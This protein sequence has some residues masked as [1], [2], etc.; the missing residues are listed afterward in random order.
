MTVQSVH[1]K[2]GS[3]SLVLQG[4]PAGVMDRLDYFGHIAV[5]PGVVNPVE[6][7]DEILDLARFVGVYRRKAFARGALTISGASLAV[8][9][10]DEDDK[11]DI[12]EYPGITLTGSTFANAVRAILPASGS[13][14]EGTL[15]PGVAGTYTGQHLYC[16]PRAALDYICDTMRAEW[17]V[18]ND[19]TLDAGPAAS[20]FGGEPKAVIVRAGEAGVDERLRALEGNLDTETNAEDYI[21]RS[22][23]V[24]AA[25]GGGTANAASVPYKHLHGGTVKVTRLI[26]EQD[27]TSS[28]NAASRAQNFLNLWSSP[29][30]SLKLQ[31][32]SFDIE[33]DFK[34]GETVW[35]Y[36]PE[37]GIFDTANEITFRGR[38]INPMKVR[39]LG[40]TWPVTQGYTVGFRRSQ[41]GA[42]IDLTPWVQWEAASAGEI[43]ISDSPDAMLGSSGSGS[44]GT[45]IDGGG[46]GA[47]DIASP[48]AP[49]WTGYTTTT[50]ENGVGNPEAQV[51]VTWSTPNNTDGSTILDGDHYE[52]QYRPVGS[53]AWQITMVPWGTNTVTLQALTPAT[54]YE[55]QVRAVDYFRPPNYG[56]W[57]ATSI[58]VTAVDTTPP[59]TPAAPTVAGSRIAIQVKHTLGSAGGGTYNLPVDLDHLE[60]HVGATDTFTAD[61]TTRVG[62]IPANAGMILGGIPAVGSFGVEPTSAVWVRVRA[63]DKTGNKSPASDSVTVTALLIDN[64]HISDLTVSKLTAGTMTAAVILGGSIKTATTGARLELDSAGMRL[65]NASGVQ[66][67]TFTTATGAID[68]NGT[69]ATGVSGQRIRIDATSTYPTIWFKDNSGVNQSFINAPGSGLGLNTAGDGIKYSRLYLLDGQLELAVLSTGSQAISGG[70]FNATASFTQAGIRLGA[71]TP[72]R[73]TWWMNS[74]GSYY[75]AYDSGGNSRASLELKVDGNANLWG[76]SAA[77][78]GTVNNTYYYATNGILQTVMGGSVMSNQTVTVHTNYSTNFRATGAYSTTTSLGANLYVHTDGTFYRSTSTAKSKST[79]ERIDV[80]LND[81]LALQPVTYR[82]KRMYETEGDNAPVALGLIAEQVAETPLGE[83]LVGRNAVNGEPESVSYERLGV[84]L[85]G[86]VRVLAEQVA[87]LTGKKKVLAPVPLPDV[88]EE[89]SN[90][91]L[92]ESLFPVSDELAAPPVAEVVETAAE[93]VRVEATKT[94]DTLSTEGKK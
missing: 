12:I 62:K 43:Q 37:G 83:W 47:G 40:L 73:G 20:L 60:V 72:D 65:Y 49:T 77:Y 48:A 85:L 78:L 58:Q 8:W 25:L 11:G 28:T 21:T 81:V 30:R 68:I 74:T 39:V 80:G 44:Q 22:V 55:Y 56:A 3:W 5:V 41:D 14:T 36:D 24:A 15:Y 7:G 82:D 91:A 93:A 67:G 90:A 69:F 86:A 54:T 94:E 16:T 29:R 59:P 52:V 4:A 61:D 50:Y 53:P 32:S 46:R 6:R 84:A 63:V 34:P 89:L 88:V 33:G 87:E 10:G 17:R 76:V 51:S 79:I 9:L 64:A 42:W 13:I 31:A 18:N 27:V 75:Y 1:Q 2:A 35:C 71:G 92:D 38:I 19:G 45:L 57:S 23:I 66:T 70:Y 26:D